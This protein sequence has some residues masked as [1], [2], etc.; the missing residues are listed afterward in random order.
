MDSHPILKQLRKFRAIAILLAE[1]W[2]R[3]CIEG[4][5]SKYTIF[6]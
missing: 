5:S 6:R 4:I 1:R 2:L 3:G